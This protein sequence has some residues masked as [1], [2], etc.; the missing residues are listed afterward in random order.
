ME[1]RVLDYGAIGWAMNHLRLGHQM[2]RASWQASW[3]IEL[4]AG[5]QPPQ[6]ALHHNGTPEEPWEPTYADL[7]AGDWQLLHPTP[8]GETHLDTSTPSTLDVS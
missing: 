3:Y 7:L 1:A 6:I 2:R 4:D 5:V 8:P